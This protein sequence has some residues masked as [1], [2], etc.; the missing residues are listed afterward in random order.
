[1]F[2]EHGIFT[3]V[4]CYECVIDTGNAAPIAIK[5]ILYG[6]REIPIMRKS[7]AALEKVG[8][9][10]QIHD[11]QWLFK[12]LLAPKPH[13]EHVCNIEDFVWRFC[14]NYNPLNQVTRLVAYPIPCCDAAI[15]NAFGGRYIWLYDA[16]MGYH[17]ISASKETQQKLTFQGPDAI[18]WTYTV[19]PFGPTNGPATFITMIHDL[20]SVWKQLAK[21]FGINIGNDANTVIIVDDIL[22]W[23]KT[24]PQALRYIA[25]QLRI[26]KAYRLTLSLKKSHFSLN[27][28]SLLVLMFRPMGIVLPCRSTS[29]SSIGQSLSLF[30]TWQALSDFFN[31]I[32]SS[33]PILRFVL[34]RFT[35]SWSG[36]TLR[37]L[38]TYGHPLHVKLLMTSATPFCVTL[39]CVGLTKKTHGV[40]HGLFC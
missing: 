7:I 17:Q 33:F 37:Q 3:P 11:G 2:D 38:A 32:A 23:A 40:T 31:S 8:Q 26:C 6:P 5:K 30:R 28:W 18:K 13:Q 1:M 24:F 10:R 20:H 12:A 34:N 14:V 19:M 16:P 25:C 39:A 15:D 4:R 9:I 22:N 36:I 21:D 35:G 27:G 29:F